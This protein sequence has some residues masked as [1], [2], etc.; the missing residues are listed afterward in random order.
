MHS[1]GKIHIYGIKPDQYELYE[2]LKRR[3]EAVSCW[4]II[5]SLSI[6]NSYLGTL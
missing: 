1:M 3:E 5:N 6:L 4:D 2:L